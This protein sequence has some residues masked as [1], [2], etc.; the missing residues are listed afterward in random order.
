MQE[1]RVTEDHCHIAREAI[2]KLVESGRLTYR[3]AASMSTNMHK[4]FRENNLDAM[5]EL[6]DEIIYFQTVPATA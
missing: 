4:A 5:S 2:N 3:T 6:L 1:V